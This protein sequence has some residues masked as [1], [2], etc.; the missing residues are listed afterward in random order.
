MLQILGYEVVQA[1]LVGKRSELLNERQAVGV[2][3]VLQHLAPQRSLTERLEPLLQLS[4]VSIGRSREACAK[5]LD[6]AEREVIDDAD[7]SIQL[8]QRIL[9]RRRSQQNFRTVVNRILHGNRDPAA[10]LVDVAKPV[11]FIDDDEIPRCLLHVRFFAP[12]E[13]IR[14]NHDCLLLERVQV[15][16]A[17]SV[18]E[19][20]FLEDHGAQEELI[21]KLL[22]PLLAKI[23]RHDDQQPPLP[24][25]PM[26]RQKKP[27][28]DRLSESDLIREDGALRKRI[29]KG[30]K[31]SLDLMRIEIDLRVREH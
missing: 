3:H 4:K 27:G 9:K 22:A 7:E 23:R 10:R 21:G 15:P 11:G 14:A 25:G 8:E 13:L 31:C 24:L 6:V 12:H 26:L 5:A 28:F 1:L 20:A 2:L 16:G 17:N 18:I 30:E 19:R 29:T